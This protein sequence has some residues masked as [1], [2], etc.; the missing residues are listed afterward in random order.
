MKIKI[1]LNKL[2]EKIIESDIFN[3]IEN[4][5]DFKN[6]MSEEFSYIEDNDLI[7]FLFDEYCEYMGIINYK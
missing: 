5:N 2:V 3:N 7:K 1:N 4:F 6:N